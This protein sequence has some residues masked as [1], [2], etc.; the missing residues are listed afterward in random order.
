MASGRVLDQLWVISCLSVCLSVMSA[1]L[2]LSLQVQCPGSES[3]TARENMN[4]GGRREVE[5]ESQP[6]GN[7]SVRQALERNR[8][9]IHPSISPGERK[10]QR[11]P[12]AKASTYGG[13]AFRAPRAPLL[14]SCS[15]YV[16]ESVDPPSR[17]VAASHER[18]VVVARRS[19]TGLTG[20][21]SEASCRPN[22]RGDG[23]RASSTAGRPAKWLP[24][25]CWRR[26]ANSESGS[27]IRAALRVSPLWWYRAATGDSVARL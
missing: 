11:A 4:K 14:R 15:R 8:M 16:A 25:C 23:A 27:P 22:P 24:A 3:R 19:R 17:P 1:Y 6:A 13:L 20:D 9:P 21:R 7:E 18:V 10:P 12:A 5:V 2:P 26:N